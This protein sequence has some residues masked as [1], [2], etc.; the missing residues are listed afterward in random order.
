[1]NNTVRATLSGLPKEFIQWLESLRHKNPLAGS[2]AC[3]NANSV[4]VEIGKN[5]IVDT[6]LEERDKALNPRAPEMGP[7]DGSE[8]ILQP[9]T[10]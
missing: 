1:M 9:V 10:E 8:I 2:D 5:I 7:I 4:F 3:R 6:I